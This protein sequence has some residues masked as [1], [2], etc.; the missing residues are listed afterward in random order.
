MYKDSAPQIIRHC[1][2]NSQ[3]TKYM[4]RS[5]WIGRLNSAKMLD[6]SKLIY[7]F[8]AMKKKKKTLS[9]RKLMLNAKSLQLWLTLCNPLD[10]SPPGSSVHKLLQARIQ[11]WVAMTS[12]R[13][14]SLSSK[15]SLD[16][17][18]VCMEPSKNNQYNPEKRKM[19]YPR[20]ARIL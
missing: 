18:K 15:K 17:S 3:K 10:S 5:S 2:K 8:N 14:S 11:E 1:R 6:L 20:N 12:S 19:H 9:W 16:D 13:G 4:E 7:R